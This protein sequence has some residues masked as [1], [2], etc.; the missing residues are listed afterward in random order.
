MMGRFIRAHC[1]MET[2]VLKGR[3]M[4]DMPGAA[5]AMVIASMDCVA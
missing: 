4:A 1:P 3:M 5:R 2:A